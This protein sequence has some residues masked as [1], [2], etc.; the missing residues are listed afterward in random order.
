ME[1]LDNSEIHALKSNTVS[2]CYETLWSHIY[3]NKKKAGS[4]SSLFPYSIWKVKIVNFVCWIVVK[5][6]KSTT[7]ICILCCL[8]HDSVSVSV[9]L[10]KLIIWNL[11]SK[12]P[13]VNTKSSRH[14]AL[15]VGQFW[16]PCLKHSATVYHMYQ[17]KN[18]ILTAKNTQHYNL[19]TVLILK[20]DVAAIERSIFVFEVLGHILLQL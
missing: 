3:V 9:L 20:P 5:E 7:N 2:L 15:G 11:G 18:V 17:A 10:F 19:P 14:L 8:S 12:V 1:W 16:T 13:D 6:I 4:N